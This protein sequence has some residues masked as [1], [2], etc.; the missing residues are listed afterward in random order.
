[1]RSLVTGGTGFVGA[2]LVRRLVAEGDDVH[3]LVREGHDPW[4]IDHLPV[5]KHAGSSVAEIEPDRV[6]HLAVHGGYAWQT[7]AEE[8]VRTNVLGTVRL[9]DA[10][11]AAGVPV[12]VNTGTS[13]EYGVKDHAPREDEPLEPNSLY[14]VT[15]AAATMYACHVARTTGLRVVTLRLYSVYGPYEQPGRL[16]PALVLEGL[17]GRLPPLVRPEISR[18]FVHVDDVCDAYLLAAE[19]GERVYNVGSGRR[20]TIADLVGI[21]RRVLGIGQDPAWGAMDERGWDTDIWVA[22]PSRI[23]QELGWRARVQLED[24]FGRTVEW[25]RAHPE[26]AARYELAGHDDSEHGRAS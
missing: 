11:A 3:L 23:M 7:D 13:S 2:N 15:K 10:C 21:A 14:A 8:I 24:G 1:M 6:F 16:V 4:R 25:F 5:T 26:F 12:V 18:D 19:R 20:T 22:D 9:L 17:R